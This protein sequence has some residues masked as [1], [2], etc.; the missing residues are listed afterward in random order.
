MSADAHQ[1]VPGLWMGEKPPEGAGLKQAGFTLL[2]L[3][4]R[5][6]QPRSSAFGI[7]VLHVPLPDGPL[8]PDQAELAHSAATRVAQ[9]V[10]KG[11]K[12]LVTCWAGANRS[13]LVTALALE[14]MGVPPQAALAKIRVKRRPNSGHVPLSNPY[15][16][17]MI[18]EAQAAA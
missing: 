2:V 10:T 3:T 14:Q 6:Y 7:P 11:G 17:L 8:K 13:G 18:L 9:E 4:A 12:V 16:V 5:E 1:I 15:F